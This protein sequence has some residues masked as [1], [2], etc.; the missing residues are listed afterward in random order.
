MNRDPSPLI[1]R[2]ALSRAWPWCLAIL[3]VAALAAPLGA[4]RSATARAATQARDVVAL[5]ADTSTDTATVTASPTPSPSATPSPTSTVA[6]QATLAASPSTTQ[7]GTWVTF[8]G[9]G[10]PANDTIAI[11]LN[12][13]ALC[14]LSS[15]TSG[16]LNSG[17]S[18]T[19]PLNLP[20]GSYTVTASD[21]AHGQLAAA[22]LSITP[23]LAVTT[24]TATP[25]GQLTLYGYGFPANDTAS[26]Y[27]DGYLLC[28]VF[29]SAVGQLASTSCTVN[30]AIPSGSY[31]LV[32]NDAGGQLAASSGVITITSSAGFT[33][34]PTSGAPGSTVAVYATGFSAYETISLYVSGSYVTAGIADA[35]G[36]LSLSFT[37]PSS[38][39]TDNQVVELLGQQSGHVE[40][41]TFDVTSVSGNL[42][43]AL[44]PGSGIAGTV[45]TASGY[46]NTAFG[47][48]Q[49][50]AI[51]F[52]ATQVAATT[53]NSLGN[54]SVS[55]SVPSGQSGAVTVAADETTYGYLA[56][57]TFTVTAPQIT[58][59]SS[60]AVP[61]TALSVT[62]AGFVP[63][64]A[65]T[66][67]L[68]GGATTS[69]T[70]D[71]SGNFTTSITLSSGLAA[72]TV[73]VSAMG[74]TSQAPATATLTIT[75]ATLTASPGSVQGGSV[76][77]ITGTDFAPGEAVVLAGSDG[78]TQTVTA[79]SVG[80]LSATLTVA[81]SQAAGTLSVIA[82]GATS[83][84]TA[85]AA[86]A[87]T[88]IPPTVTPSGTATPQPTATTTSP[89]VANTGSSAWYFASGRT[90]SSYAEQIDV[91]NPNTSPVQGTITLYYG[92][93]QST[94]SAFSLAALARGTYDVGAI[95]G[96]HNGIAAVVHAGLPIA[97]TAT[98]I[99]GTTNRSALAGVASPST[100]WYFAEGYT[101]LTFQESLDLFNPGT[102]TTTV[103]VVWPRSSGAPVHLTLTLPAHARQTI[104][105]NHYVPRASHATIISAN[106]PVVA[107]RTMVFGAHAQGTT[108]VA[109]TTSAATTLYL[110]EGST[111]NGLQEFV[112]L[113]NPHNTGS[114]H[115]TVTFYGGAG[116]A[117]GTRRLTIGALQR[118]SI[119]VNGVTHASSVAALIVSDLSVVAERAIYTGSPNGN[120]AG[121]SDVVATARTA[122]GWALASGDTSPGQKEFEVL[123][124]PG[125]SATTVLATWYTSGGLLVQQRVSLP[126]H[127][128]VTIDVTATVPSLPAGSHG[129]VLQSIDGGTFVAEQALYDG[130]LQQAA[131]SLGAPLS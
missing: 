75:G 112:S 91:L 114:A 97:V 104:S 84:Q 129:L 61:G 29:S 15:G 118:G 79:N 46:A 12:G 92:T 23:A 101:G 70:A 14:S 38:A 1:P 22:A 71:S 21:S 9:S 72:G 99:R 83:K 74:A 64:E 30:S 88:A 2:R 119:A 123:F 103:Q 55:F 67:T 50:I 73:T 19:A 108:T 82:T 126:A 62:G 107:G 113:L 130:A 47:A 56:T 60:S 78:S 26:I 32:A 11:S 59:G 109:G 110:V 31:Q 8:S 116:T 124:N 65:V 34:S 51:D 24:A 100:Q 128:R 37:Y 18:C 48:S 96:A 45:V 20:K 98:T 115:V 63:G 4:G 33:L 13:V 131:A 87:V 93:G 58:L 106:H 68:P 52:G 25:G 90:D 44:S 85:S 3:L 95:V 120:T 39:T 66:I 35:Y 105:V 17:T 81:V 86:I 28:T 16:N 42:T 7:A 6:A 41:A 111:A 121:G 102:T 53:P 94:S 89:P 40:T 77:T 80:S 125:S 127:A 117:I 57:Q 36:S 27:L 5:V 43:L 76:V 49:P 69:V 10:Y 122:T 54:Y